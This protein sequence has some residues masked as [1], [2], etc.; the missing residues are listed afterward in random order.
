MTVALNTPAKR[1]PGHAGLLA[2]VGLAGVLAIAGAIAIVGGHL[3]APPAPSSTLPAAVR[4]PAPTVTVAPT[5][6]LPN[7]V[8]GVPVMTVSELLAAR[9]A[10][11]LVDD[12]GALR[13]YWSM[14]PY[15]HS[16]RGPDHPTAALELYCRDNEYGVTELPE[17]IFE[18]A[19]PAGTVTEARGPHLTPF[20]SDDAATLAYT[21]HP[22][23]I[24]GQLFPPFPVLIVGHFNDPRAADCAPPALELCRDRFVI[25]R[26]VE[27]DWQS[28]ATPGVTPS[29]TPFPSPPPPGLFAPSD[30]P[31]IGN[32][33][34]SFLGWT[35]TKEL[36]I[37]AQREGHIWAVVARDPVQSFPDWIDGKNGHRYLQFA[38]VICFRAE[39]DVTGGM[40]LSFVSGS[41]ERH[42]DDGLITHGT[43]PRPGE[44][45]R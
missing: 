4:S 37:P 8:D 14:N 24:N 11:T 5:S 20:L 33:P 26:I 7:E 40:E 17:Q 21:S 23:V 43:D 39:W 28:V 18:V 19:L 34:Y 9:D 16:C 10:G 29:P 2:L 44:S 1:R 25:D 36:G 13:G 27:W 22:L 3:A 31:L 35:T 32:A 38:R 6:T 45:P 30:C 41:R 15:R 42:W 12:R